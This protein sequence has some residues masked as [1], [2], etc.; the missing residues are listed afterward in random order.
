MTFGTQKKKPRT[1]RD[2]YHV[3]SPEELELIGREYDS[4]R[5]LDDQRRQKYKAATLHL[6]DNL[7]IIYFK[8]QSPTQR[9]RT[10]NAKRNLNKNFENLSINF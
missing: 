7:R 2:R 5:N 1:P 9:K 8:L 3:F 6:I 10:K 4:I